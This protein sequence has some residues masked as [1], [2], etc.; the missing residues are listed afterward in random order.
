[1]KMRGGGARQRN[2]WC[3]ETTS[4]NEDDGGQKAKRMGYEADSEMLG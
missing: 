2:N 3:P 1:M 4:K